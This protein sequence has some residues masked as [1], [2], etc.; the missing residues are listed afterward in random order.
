MKQRQDEQIIK[1]MLETNSFDRDSLLHILESYGEDLALIPIMLLDGEKILRTRANDNDFF[2]YV[3]ELSYPPARYA[4]TDRASLEGKPMFYGSVFTKD[5]EQSHAYPRIVSAI[6]AIPLLNNKN[7]SGAKTITQSIWIANEPI[8]AF[9]FP[10]SDKYKR[11]CTEIGMLNN[12]WENTLRNNYTNDSINFFR[13]IG[14]LMACPKKTCLYDITSTCIDY[15]LTKLDFEGIIYPSVPVE[16]EGMNICIKPNV[17]DSKI[18]FSGAV[19][20]IVLRHAKE[21]TL[22]TLGHCTMISENSFAWIITPDGKNLMLR[23]GRINEDM[24]DKELIICSQE[25]FKERFL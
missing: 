7:D 20:E 8:H 22:V 25:L 23:L 9:S 12:D 21:S 18:S 2:S 5:V 1:Q 6:E 13:Y 16:G 3:H 19:T 4:R 24:F 11:A 17:V 10:F 15:I 14:N